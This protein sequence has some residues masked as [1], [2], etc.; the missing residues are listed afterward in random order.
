MKK[1]LKALDGVHT[2]SRFSALKAV[3]EQIKAFYP[4]NGGRRYRTV[5]LLKG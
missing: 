4:R 5:N 3:K 1:D 2:S